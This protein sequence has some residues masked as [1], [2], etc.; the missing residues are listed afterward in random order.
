MRR[1]GSGVS[2]VMIA[3]AIAASSSL[4]RATADEAPADKTE[5]SLNAEP[6]ADD[7]G[8]AP[9]SPPQT[10]LSEKTS[11]SEAATKTSE[12]PTPCKFVP[13]A[14]AALALEAAKQ[15][16]NRDPYG[17]LMTVPED[18]GG[19][20]DLPATNRAVR[21]IIK[22]RPGE[23]LVICIAGCPTTDRVVY[24]QPAEKIVQSSAIGQQPA[25]VVADAAA[26]VTGSPH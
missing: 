5:V 19:N 16:G 12:E 8:A 2:L 20:D 13:H 25:S 26:P 21:D 15:S 3:V 18:G 10:A 24:S 9:T 23:E 17:K 6:K 11:A 7:P 14:Q 22:A 4:L 1:S